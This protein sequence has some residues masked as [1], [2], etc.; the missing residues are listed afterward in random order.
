M[1][2]P[3]LTA[4]QSDAAPPGTAPQREGNSALVV[5]AANGLEKERVIVRPPSNGDDVL[6]N[7]WT[8]DARSL[9]L[10]SRLPAV[11]RSYSW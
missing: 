7:A 3:S 9:V 5:K 4:V 8:P 2:Y 11:A 6:P 1:P 10:P